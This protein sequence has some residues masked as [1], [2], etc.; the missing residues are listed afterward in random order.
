MYNKAVIKEVI[1]DQ[2]SEIAGMVEK[3]HVKR[4]IEQKVR[5]GL[6]DA[7]VKVI[8]GVRRSGKSVLAHMVLKNLPYGYVNFDDERLSGLETKDLNIVFEV[9]LELTPGM[10]YILLDEIQNIDKWELFVNRLQ[11]N[12]YKII[13]TGSNAHL[14]SKDLAT[15]L[16]GRHRVFELYPFSF[17][18]YLCFRG[19]DSDKKQIW[20]TRDKSVIASF[21]DEYFTSGGFPEVFSVVDKK[22][23]LRD[24]YNKILTQDIALRYKIRHTKTLKDVALYTANNY[25]SKLSYQNIKEAYS[26]KSIHTVKNYLS[27]MEEAYLFFAVES[28]SHKLRERERMPRKMYGIDPALLRA[29]SISGQKNEGRLLENLVYL[30]LI[31]RGYQ[32]QYYSDS[33]RK[34]EVDF[35]I[36][37]NS[38]KPTSLVQVCADTGVAEIKE[39]E[40]RGL[41][42]ALKFFGKIE[43]IFIV[44]LNQSGTE[45]TG[46][47]RVQ[48]VPIWQ[49]LLR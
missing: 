3:Y 23:Y 41:H 10:K 15:H 47:K 42:S 28:F 34:Y 35:V 4:S 44:T 17:A 16:T 13:I 18:E 5:A 40:M 25:A 2:K 11:R 43:E 31:R 36:V 46:G 26:L 33:H 48:V 9:L 39:R 14:L 32:T 45:T 49:W 21:F 20:S 38:G 12:G 22:V 29:I 37:D 7:L 27:Y 19:V 24:L 6:N 1:I 8:S 30:E